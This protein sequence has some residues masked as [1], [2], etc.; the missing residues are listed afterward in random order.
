M[1]E[2]QYRYMYLRKAWH[3]ETYIDT[4]SSINFEKLQQIIITDSC[5]VFRLFLKQIKFQ[6]AY[7]LSKLEKKRVVADAQ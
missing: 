5:L 3:L 2:D 1:H 7:I 6:L 4:Y